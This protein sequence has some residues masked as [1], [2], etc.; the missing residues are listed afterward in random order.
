MSAKLLRKLT[1]K[2]YRDET[3]L[4]LVEGRKGIEELLRSDFKVDS[5]YATLESMAAFEKTTAACG[6]NPPLHCLSEEKLALSGTFRTNNAGIA[7]AH[8][9][10]ELPQDA[11]LK[12]AQS[13]W[14]L[15]LDDVRDPGNLGTIMRTADW[16]G[17]THIVTSETSVDVWNPKVVSASMGSFTRV[18]V[19]SCNL[20]AF[21]TKAREEKL[22]VLGAFLEG[23]SIYDGLEEHK[24]FLL[25]GS[26]SHGIH[27]ELVPLV[28]EKITIPRKGGAESLNVSIATALILSTL[29]Q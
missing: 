22:P 7:I 24:G 5:I 27:E 13:G 15:V 2:K 17:I 18:S 21:L 6:K 19:S 9:K 23:K 1:E 29:T 4:F 25:M 10:P 11:Y 14:V 16:F 20:T 12:A 28:S 8:Q 3:G 26:E